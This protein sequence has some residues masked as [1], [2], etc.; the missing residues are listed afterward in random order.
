MDG[1][2]ELLKVTSALRR[3]QEEEA[4][5]DRAN[6]GATIPAGDGWPPIPGDIQET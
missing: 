5:L 4:K 2:A 1:F 3:E 6:G